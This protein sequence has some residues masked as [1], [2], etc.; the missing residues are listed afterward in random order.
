MTLV[1][2]D[3]TQLNK[4]P[5]GTV[6]EAV[7]D[8]DPQV[9]VLIDVYETSSF[10]GTNYPANERRVAF[11]AGKVIYQREWD[12]KFTDASITSIVPSGGPAAGGTAVTITGKAF[13]PT[14]TVTFGGTA[15][16]SIVVVNS[17]KITCVTPAKSAGAYDVVATSSAGAVTKTNGFTYA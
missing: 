8:K 5:G 3:G 9:K 2:A 1:K 7:T 12:A 4:A 13:T 15:A 6:L 14:T 16:T 10:D 11:K 17:K